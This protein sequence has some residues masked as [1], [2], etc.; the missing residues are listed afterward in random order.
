MQQSP[1]PQSPKSKVER[2]IAPRRAVRLA[3][4]SPFDAIGI[5][6]IGVGDRGKR[7][8]TEVMDTPGTQLRAVCDIYKPRLAY[9]VD[10][11]RKFNPEVRGYSDYRKVL[12]DPGVDAIIVATPDHWHSRITVDGANAGKDIYVQKCLTRTLP[13]AKAIV[14]SVKANKSVLQL[15]HTRRSEPLYHRMREI[16]GSGVLGP[17]SSA[18][19]TMYRNTASGAWDWKIEPEGSPE[20]ID[21]AQFLG[22]APQ[23]PFDP[24]RFFRWR[25]YWDYGTGISGDLLSHEWDALNFVMD[26]G[27]PATCIASGGIYCWKEK[28]EVPDVL[29][30]VYDYTA[31]GLAVMWNCTFSNSASGINT[32]THI[33]GKNASLKYDYSDKLMQVFL[34]PLVEEGMEHIRDIKADRK[35]TGQ[36]CDCGTPLYSFAR[37]EQS[38]ATSHFQNFIDCVRSRQKTRC[39]EDAAFEEAVTSIMSVI[40]Y[41]EKRLVRWDPVKQEI[42]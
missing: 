2:P 25:K 19:I 6:L 42:V 20:T 7:H 12:D 3:G 13:E 23:R 21:W 10:T 15:G 36:K 29:N 27:I 28:R 24:D 11:V 9:A 4:R 8:L 34:E 33:L 32:G 31:R 22:S 38:Y 41:K 39:N 37:D 30:V 1:A 14:N 18:N 17:V 5:G 26:L 35:K 40:A 16:Y